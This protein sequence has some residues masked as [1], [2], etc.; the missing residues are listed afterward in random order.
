MWTAPCLLVLPYLHIQWP[1]CQG[2]LKCKLLVQSTDKC[3][4]VHTKAHLYRLSIECADIR[5]SRPG[6]ANRGPNRC[7]VPLLLNRLALIQQDFPICILHHPCICSSELGECSEQIY[8]VHGGKRGR[9]FHQCKDFSLS[10]GT[11]LL[12]PQ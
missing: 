11:I 12:V 6:S 5:D 9:L 3:K 7:V 10:N 1:I 8:G 2:T 4:S